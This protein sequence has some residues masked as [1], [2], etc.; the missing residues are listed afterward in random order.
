MNTK[1]SPKIRQIKDTDKAMLLDPTIIGCGFLLFP[2]ALSKVLEESH[3][4]QALQTNKTALWHAV[5]QNNPAIPVHLI[6]TN[7]NVNPSDAIVALDRIG[8]YPGYSVA[9]D[10][11]QI[12]ID[13]GLTMITIYVGFN[14][15]S[16]NQEIIV[17]GP[18]MIL[19]K[20]T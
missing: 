8:K 19:P 13:G 9:L 1:S 7:Q 18:Q 4:H 10:P 16:T 3:I 15:K 12:S 20:Y 17:A 6:T 11:M 14:W 2:M 5:V